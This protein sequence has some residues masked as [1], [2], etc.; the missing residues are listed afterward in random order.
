MLPMLRSVLF[1]AL[2]PRDEAMAG[3]YDY[4]TNLVLTMP[5]QTGSVAAEVRAKAD[6][7]I[8][9]YRADGTQVWL[10]CCLLPDEQADVV[11]PGMDARFA[12]HPEAVARAELQGGTFEGPDR[13]WPLFPLDRLGEVLSKMALPAM[14]AELALHQPGDGAR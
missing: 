2:S 10:E 12:L 1:R 13:E 8:R 9:F 7:V 4:L 11:L 14:A 5:S 3:I 6:Q